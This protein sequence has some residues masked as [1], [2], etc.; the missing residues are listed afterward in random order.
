MSKDGVKKILPP[1]KVSPSAPQIADELLVVRPAAGKNPGQQQPSRQGQLGQGIALPGAAIY[2]AMKPQQ[3]HEEEEISTFFRTRRMIAQGSFGMNPLLKLALF[4]L[5]L[6]AVLTISWNHAA[7]VRIRGQKFMMDTFQVNPSAYIPVW[8][9]NAKI[10]K[11]RMASARPLYEDLGAGSTSGKTPAVDPLV[12]AVVYGLWPQVESFSQARCSRWLATHECAVRAWYL[13]YRG[14]KASL[15]SLTTLDLSLLPLRDQILFQY[16]I[17]VALDRGQS[18]VAFAKAQELS[19]GD[20][21]AQSMIFDARLKLLIREARTAEVSDLMRQMPSSGV[22][23][24]EKSKWRALD[25]FGTGAFDQLSSAGRAQSIKA[26]SQSLQKFPGVFKSDPLALVL[27]SSLAL[28]KGLVKP[29]AAIASSAVADAAKVPMDPGLRREMATAL[30]RALMLDGQLSQA[31]ERLKLA[32]KLDGPDAVTNHVLGSLA[33]ESRSR[34]RIKD[35][36]TYFNLA[37]KGQERWESLFGYLLAL[38][39]VGQLQDATRTAGLLR[40]KIT[41]DN[42]MW[43]LLAMAEYKLAAVKGASDESAKFIL[44]EQTRILSA[45]HEKNPWSTWAGRLYVEALTRTGQL[46]QAQKIVAKMDDVSGK[47]S[48]LSSQEFLASPTGPLALLR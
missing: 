48:Y 15:R 33:L 19:K 38:T 8:T 39:R 28:K 35:A 43:I 2:P 36:L 13:S 5:L 37:L 12:Q 42:E 41:K 22:P 9:K 46:T 31:T 17:S 14:M 4:V 3:P 16:A 11:R 25:F 30:A 26:F 23:E 27:V 1:T 10:Y 34:D 20:D 44:R 32:Q 18:A 7:P 47:T 6:G 45:V 40:A 29:I 24:S 21:V